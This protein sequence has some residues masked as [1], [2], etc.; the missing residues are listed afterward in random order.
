M[1]RP[2]NN[3]E[4]MGSGDTI[5][6]SGKLNK[7]PCNSSCSGNHHFGVI[8]SKQVGM[9]RRRPFEDQEPLEP[10]QSRPR[11]VA[12]RRHG[13]QALQKRLASALDVREARPD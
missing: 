5:L 12:H 3:S 6:P 2:T 1:T 7:R 10:R 11:A 13:A 8:P 4:R 9:E